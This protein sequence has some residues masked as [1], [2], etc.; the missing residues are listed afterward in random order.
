[1]TEDG[2]DKPKIHVDE[3][4]KTQARAEKEKL[5]EDTDSQADQEQPGQ[6]PQ[7]NFTTLINSLMMQALMA[8]GGVEDP[9]TKKRVVDLNLA[10]FHID[11]LG[12]L[13]EKTKGNLT[14]E[15]HKILEQVLHELRMGFMGFSKR[16]QEIADGA[17]PQSN[18]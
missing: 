14:D 9:A 15:E 11:I 4:W 6:L 2:A 10:R 3:D 1:M 12:V 18:A 7:A 17:E 8:M 5:A 16:A 13:E